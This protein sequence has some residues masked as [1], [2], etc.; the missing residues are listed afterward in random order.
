MPWSSIISSGDVVAIHAALVP[1]ANGDGEILLLGGDNH[2]RDGAVANQFDHTR[3]FNCRNTA[4]ALI[5]VE[6]PSFDL[7]CSGHAQLPEGEVLPE[8]GVLFAGGTADFPK[9]AHG[10]HKDIHF[11]GHRHAVI[12]DPSAGTFVV[13][14][15]MNAR[16]GRKGAG[17]GR[18][19]PTVCTLGNGNL[20]IA[21][22]HP[23]GSDSRHGNDTPEI[24]DNDVQTWTLLPKFG[25][26]SGNP[27]LYPRLHLLPSGLIFISSAI[28]GYNQNISIDPSSSVTHSV[29]SLPDPAYHG[30][31]CPS[32]LLPLVPADQYRAR[33][34]LCGGIYTQMIDLGDSNPAWS[35]VTRNGSAA[36][37]NRSHAC[38]T[39]LPTG[40]VL[41]TGGTSVNDQVGV[42]LPEIYRTPIDHN[43]HSYV[44]GVGFSET[45]NE[46]ATIIRNYH[47]TALLMPDGR[48]WTAGGNSLY[49]PDY[50]ATATQK[51]IEIFDPPYPTGPRPS[52]VQCP[53]FVAYNHKFEISTPQANNISGISLLRCG[54]S[55]HAF[56][57]DQRMIVLG[58]SK[59]NANTLESNAPPNCNVAPPGSYMLFLI[60]NQGRPCSYA[61]FVRVGPRMIKKPVRTFWPKKIYKI[62][63]DMF[64]LLTERKRA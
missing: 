45:I 42:L 12:Y 54:S 24:F 62:I 44:G 61:K 53:S 41:I 33:V 64:N 20:F 11:D 4:S 57:P 13:T 3:R 28:D 32:V 47:S 39:L 5:Y 1:T 14:S 10:I 25:I 31:D 18:W 35:A 55:T 36:A 56:N 60:D 2:Y 6:S 26:I 51:S 63:L 48:V 21:Q 46:P 29:S 19:Y 34:L 17:G 9:Y 23:S 15:D 38:A 58:F 7:F 59:V 37:F 40:D 43:T 52:I 30:F 8:G 50:P 27:I 49:Q 22:G 16:L